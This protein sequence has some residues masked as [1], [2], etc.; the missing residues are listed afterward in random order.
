MFLAF[1]K[2]LNDGQIFN[3]NMFQMFFNASYMEYG[4]GLQTMSLKRDSVQTQTQ[5]LKWNNIL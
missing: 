3:G 4:Q 2:W 5:L 1:F